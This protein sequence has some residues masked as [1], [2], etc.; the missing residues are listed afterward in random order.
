[1]D[2]NPGKLNNYNASSDTA[3]DMNVMNVMNDMNAKIAKAEAKAELL[4]SVVSDLKAQINAAKTYLI[5]FGRGNLDAV[6]L[7]NTNVLAGPIKEIHSQISALALNM[8][9]LASGHIVG[10]LF[11]QGT[12]F[13]E[14]NSLIGKVASLSNESSDDSRNSDETD[15]S[16]KNVN[17]WRYH[18]LLSALNHLKI[19][20]MEVLENGTILYA[21]LPAKRRIGRITAFSP[22]I[23]PPNNKNNNH[24]DAGDFKNTDNTDNIDNNKENKRDNDSD[25]VSLL[26]YLVY[27]SNAPP[28]HIKFPIF[29]EIQEEDNVWYKITTEHVTFVDGTK[30]YMHVVDDISLW[31]KQETTLIHTATTDPLTKTY[32]R[33]AGIEALEN[34]VAYSEKDDNHCI[35][36]IDLDGL[37][38]INDIFGHQEGDRAIKSISNVLMANVRE[39]DIVFRYGGDEF[40]IVFTKC[41]KMLAEKA[42]QR[43][44]SKINVL[45]ESGAYPYLL[46]FSHGIMEINPEDMHDIESVINSV[47]QLMY[48]NKKR[49]KMARQ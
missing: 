29:K 32:S 43:M 30:G 12:V 1:M 22:D 5:E 18:Q 47:D 40:V 14:F 31:K 35:A 7:D 27:F 46:S 42:L 19:M 17:S 26:E 2:E 24:D 20:I 4:S 48:E 23:L 9:H 21:N 49:K 13:Q 41:T 39:K 33:R 11:Y 16:D 25:S 34:I 45:N 36:F 44:Y 3:T 6:Q 8:K 38:I 10:K 37:K 15:E 28:N